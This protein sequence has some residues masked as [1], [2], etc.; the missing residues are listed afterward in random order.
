MAD[1]VL[2]HALRGGGRQGHEGHLGKMRAQI[3]NLAVFRPEIVAPFAD[4]MRL[5]NGDQAHVPAL[6]IRQEAG[7]HQALRRGVQQAVLAPVQAAQPPA[8]F[9]RRQGRV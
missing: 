6:Q 8:G 5:V 1:N 2:A 9:L 7:E 3:G 4:A